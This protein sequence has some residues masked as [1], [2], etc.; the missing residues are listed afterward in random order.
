MASN[1]EKKFR[2]YWQGIGGPP[3]VPEF[4]F[5]PTR[6]WRSDFAHPGARVL[7]ELEGIFFRPTQ[8]KSRHQTGTGY[9]EDCEKY[10][11]AQFHHWDVFRLTTVD[12]PTLERLAQ[13]IRWREKIFQNSTSQ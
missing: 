8:G 6:R 12:V 4:R 5:H 1:L 9:R 3:L 11:E 2:L 10:N 7:I 13:F